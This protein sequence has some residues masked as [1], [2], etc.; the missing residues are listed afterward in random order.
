MKEHGRH[1]L[2]IQE[3]LQDFHR[4]VEQ[5]VYEIR[6]ELRYDRIR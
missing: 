4:H 6:Y 5:E 3:I 1:I 2:G